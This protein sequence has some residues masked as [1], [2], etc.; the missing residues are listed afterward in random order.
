MK[1]DPV[2]RKH[3]PTRTCV[4]CHQIKPKREMVRIVRTPAG[5]IAT[6]LTGKKAGRGAY[7][8]RQQSCWETAL[9]RKSLEHALETTLT[10][11]DRERLVTFA[12]TLPAS[13]IV[14]PAQ[15]ETT[16]HP[17]PARYSA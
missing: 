2:R 7:L 9:K 4:G 8:C 6:D 5:E 12:A 10:P 11:E 3:V 14:E 16:A 15:E 17:H 13:L 1:K